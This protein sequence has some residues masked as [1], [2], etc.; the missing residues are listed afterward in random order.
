MQN[1]WSMIGIA[2]GHKHYYKN[3]SSQIRQRHPQHK[4][5]LPYHAKIVLEAVLTSGAHA[6]KRGM[7]VEHNVA[8]S[9][10]KIDLLHPY[11]TLCV[12]FRRGQL[13]KQFTKSNLR[14][15]TNQSNVTIITIKSNPRHSNSSN[16][17]INTKCNPKDSVP[18]KEGKMKQRELLLSIKGIGYHLICCSKSCDG[19]P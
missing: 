8:V 10:V 15:F 12:Q 7:V 17:V 19:D 13:F 5:L 14:N 11:S 9:T 4:S 18:T 3:V 16:S 1:F 2:R 6:K